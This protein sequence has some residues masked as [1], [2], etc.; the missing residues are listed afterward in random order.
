[1]TVKDY[2]TLTPYIIPAGS[3]KVANVGDGLILAAVMRLFGRL[4]E[5]RIFTSR[6]A[7]TGRDLE[8]CASSKLVIMA[9]ANQL[10]QNFSVLP[11][12]PSETIRKWSGKIVPVGVGLHGEPESMGPLSSEAKKQ[13]ELIHE[14]VEFSSWRCPRTITWLSKE[15]PH[16]ADRFVMTGCPV[17]YDEPLLAES[18]FSDADATIAVTPTDRGA[19]LEREE[20]ILIEVARLFKTQRKYLVFH[21]NFFLGRYP[22]LKQRLA[23]APLIGGFADGRHRLRAL[24]QSLGYDIVLL[25]TVEEC[26]SLYKDIDL[27][28]GTRLHAHLYFLSQNKRTFLVPVDQRAAGFADFLSFP[29]IEPGKLESHLGFDF[30]IVREAAL[31]TFEKMKWFVRKTEQCAMS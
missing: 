24:A 26:I 14:R 28:V 21:Q 31:S 18:R 10:H 3:R 16:L 7:P 17:L 19:F 27:H 6:V 5:A 15:L 8:K 9:G 12:V 20:A 30:E 23:A 29:L 22:R 25:D 1:M 2:A 4:D 11:G 13:L